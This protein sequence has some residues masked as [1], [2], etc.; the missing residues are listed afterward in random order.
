MGTIRNTINM[1]MFITW[2]EYKREAAERL[3]QER[4]SLSTMSDESESSTKSVGKMTKK[5]SNNKDNKQVTI[6]VESTTKKVTNKKKDKKKNHVLGGGAIV[7]FPLKYVHPHSVRDAAFPV[8]KTGQLVSCAGV[9]LKTT[10]MING[11]KVDCVVVH[12]QDFRDENNQP[13]DIYVKKCH[14]VV[15]KEGNREM[16]Y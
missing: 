1:P 16:F 3:Q 15:E 4:A 2:A 9:L 14:V 12:H 5:A 6:D 8:R 7:S 11:E 13:V 10:K